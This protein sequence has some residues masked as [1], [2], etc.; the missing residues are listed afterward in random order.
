MAVL[1]VTERYGVFTGKAPV[2]MASRYRLGYRLSTHWV[3]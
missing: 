2:L 1:V 3:S